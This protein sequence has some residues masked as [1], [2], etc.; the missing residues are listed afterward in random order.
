MSWKVGEKMNLIQEIR[1]IETKCVKNKDWYYHEI[2]KGDYKNILQNG[3]ECQFCCEEYN[4][5]DKYYISVYKERIENGSVNV[6][7][8][9][10][11]LERCNPLAVIGDIHAIPCNDN[12]KYNIFKDTILPL[13]YSCF[14]DEYQVFWKIKPEKIIGLECALLNWSKNY[15]RYFLEK[16]DQ[17]KEIIRYMESLG[18]DLPI[19]DNSLKLENETLEV[20]KEGLL[21]LSR[22]L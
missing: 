4:G 9:Y 7:D 12:P 15:S 10:Y 5:E 19:Y 17:V 8:Y 6:A 22:K 16:I 18:I 20:D 1:D 21:Y 13:R 11:S 2:T 14:Y 3:L